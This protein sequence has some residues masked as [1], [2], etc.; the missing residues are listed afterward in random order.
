VSTYTGTGLTII[1]SDSKTLTVE[2]VFENQKVEAGVLASYTY[3]NTSSGG[4]PSTGKITYSSNKQSVVKK[5]SFTGTYAFLRCN[6]TH[7]G[8]VGTVTSHAKTSL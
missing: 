5:V 6:T 4:T 7:D 2:T 1:A 3:I 8:T